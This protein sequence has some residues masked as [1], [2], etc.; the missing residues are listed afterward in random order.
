MLRVWSETLIAAVSEDVEFLGALAGQVDSHFH[1][2]IFDAGAVRAGA[3]NGCDNSLIVWD[4]TT[5]PIADLNNYLNANPTTLRT[6]S[7]LLVCPENGAES[8]GHVTEEGAIDFIVKPA[9]I[10]ELRARLRLARRPWV[11][12]MRTTFDFLGSL[13][14]EFT[15]MEQRILLCFLASPD[16]SASRASINNELWK[17][18]AVNSNS[19]DVHLFNIRR[20]IEPTGLQIRFNNKRGTWI[21]STKTLPVPT[22]AEPARRGI[23]E[24]ES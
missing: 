7:L 16:F 13:N 4:L 6:C 21:L 11:R 18:S 8:A 1:L 10:S 23:N 14:V 5:L 12:A 15:T 24:S 17:S 22:T 2:K 3:L 20:K 9:R 19:L